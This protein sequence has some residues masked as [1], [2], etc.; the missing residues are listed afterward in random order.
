MVDWDF[1]V[2]GIGFTM[3]YHLF[4]WGFIYWDLD[5]HGVWLG[6]E[7]G[8]WKD[9]QMGNVNPGLSFALWHDVD[10]EGLW[11]YVPSGNLL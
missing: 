9:M 4:S 5:F 6:L 2:Y 8:N 1:G 10:F 7:L 3:V 11:N